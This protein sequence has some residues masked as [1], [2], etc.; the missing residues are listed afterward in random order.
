M[1]VPSLDNPDLAYET[2]IHFG[3][4]CLQRFRH[5]TYRYVLS[6]DRFKEE[7]FYLRVLVPLIRN[8]YSLEPRTL[9]CRGSIFLYVYSKDLFEFKH[10]SLGL[11]VGRKSQLEH[12][13]Q[14]V[15]GS[16]RAWIAEFLSGLYDADG[17]VKARRTLFGKYPRISFA[18]KSKNVVQE[19]Q[20]LLLSTFSITST[21]YRNDYRDWRS[22]AVETRW[23]LDINGNANF[24][25]FRSYIGSRSPY[26]LTRM[27]AFPRMVWVLVSLSPPRF[28]FR[29]EIMEILPV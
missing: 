22:G 20:R 28:T 6:G 9:E 24:E 7:R 13:P 29:V 12:L 1:K 8:L 15:G 25:R 18:Q 17:S 26:V 10:H 21:M 11:T 4:G 14:I 2:G 23:F 5:H 19:V 27:A 3:D 16:S